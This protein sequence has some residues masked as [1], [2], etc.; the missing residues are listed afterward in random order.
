MGAL[1]NS[2]AGIR[3]KQTR[4]EIVK[5]L[6]LTALSKFKGYGKGLKGTNVSEIEKSFVIQVTPQSEKFNI[7]QSFYEKA[8]INSVREEFAKLI[9]NTDWVNQSASDT[10]PEAIAKILGSIAKQSGGKVTI[11]TTPDAKAS[12]SKKSFELK[13]PKEKLIKV[14]VPRIGK[15]EAQIQPSSPVNLRSLIPFLNQRLPEVVRSNMGQNGRLVNRTGR[16]A[17]SAQIV[18]IEEGYITYS[19]MLSPYQVFERDRARDPRPL[20]DQS[21]R[22]LA[23][24]IMLDKFLTR[25]I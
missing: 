20:I 10:V 9:S 14:P 23:T 3:E 25:R 19:Y 12:S 7:G 5:L 15:L 1:R 21:I 6:N 24:E 8:F 13:P 17:E 16:F 4:K 11:N 2:I 18:N 22:E